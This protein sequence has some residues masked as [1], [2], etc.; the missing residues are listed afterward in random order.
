MDTGME[1]INNFAKAT[2]GKVP[3]IVGL[4]GQRN[5]ELAM[6]QFRENKT[7]YL[8]RRHLEGKALPLIAIAVSAANGQ[9]DSVKL[10]FSLAKKFNV[11]PLEV[12]DALKAA[13]M[14]LM[15]ST[16]SSLQETLKLIEENGHAVNQSEQVD[17]IIKKIQSESGMEKLPEGILALSKFS[18]DL[19]ME[20]LKEKSELLSPY[21][22]STKLIYLIAYAVSVSI[23]SDEC[24][25]IYLGQSLKAGAKI[26]E[27]ED[28]LAISRFITGN[29][30]YITSVEIL[31]EM[32]NKVEV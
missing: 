27:I 16:M 13:K 17:K 11:E 6:E 28:A 18:F 2:L 9:K 20:H 29:K 5:E 3:E 10:H 7:L 21:K 30:A 31:Q 22:I 4:L 32:G 24:V 15:A 1:E 26:G 25:T 14:A 19:F 12:L 8:G 23:H